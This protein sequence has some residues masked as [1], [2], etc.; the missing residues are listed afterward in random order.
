MDFHQFYIDNVSSESSSHVSGRFDDLHAPTGSE[1]IRLR[2]AIKR[3][4]RATQSPMLMAFEQQ[5]QQGDEPLL[6]NNSCHS[7]IRELKL[8][9]DQ[10][11]AERRQ[12]TAS[13]AAREKKIVKELEATSRDLEA[14]VADILRKHT[15][16]VY[17]QNQLD[18][19]KVT[20]ETHQ[21]LKQFFEWRQYELN[22]EKQDL[23]R[24]QVYVEEALHQRVELLNRYA[25]DQTDGAARQLATSYNLLQQLSRADSDSQSVTSMSVTGSDELRRAAAIYVQC[26]ISDSSSVVSSAVLANIPFDEEDQAEVD[27][28]LRPL[29]PEIY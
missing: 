18:T 8:K 7:V 26:P 25:K 21:D 2:E 22:A 28:D 9:A 1:L 27:V 23:E 4:Y 29:V 19:V 16:L 5:Q 3:D 10:L 17:R 14:Y 13:W 11:E 12:T 6:V 20:Y 24:K 15:Q